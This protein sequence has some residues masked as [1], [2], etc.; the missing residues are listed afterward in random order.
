VYGHHLW[1]AWTTS[2]SISASS[3]KIGWLAGEHFVSSPQAVENSQESLQ[4]QEGGACAWF[5]CKR[6]P[7]LYA[8]LPSG[9]LGYEPGRYRAALLRNRGALGYSSWGFKRTSN[10]AIGYRV[11]KRSETTAV[12]PLEVA[13]EPVMAERFQ[14]GPRRAARHSTAASDNAGVG[15]ERAPV[16]KG[17]VHKGRMGV[18]STLASG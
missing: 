7:Q 6:P 4:T 3:A 12:E 5:L 2:A 18:S 13:G 16:S 1:T 8:R 14:R 15:S 11:M 9:H 10:V 17:C